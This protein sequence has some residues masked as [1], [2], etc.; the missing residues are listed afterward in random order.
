MTAL[1]IKFKN[2]LLAEATQSWHN[3]NN[4]EFELSESGN[5]TFYLFK[6]ITDPQGN[7][8]VAL[9]HTFT[10][11]KAFVKDFKVETMEEI[12]AMEEADLWQ[13]FNR[14]SADLQCHVEH[15]LHLFT[16]TNQIITLIAHN[17]EEKLSLPAF[18]F[19]RNE[20][21]I[22]YC[23]RQYHPRLSAVSTL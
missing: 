19:T 21:Y 10:S 23:I 22:N 4:I 18:Q 1:H 15:V 9:H 17:A 12:Q 16:K 2:L 3:K 6:T 7:L 14:G 5:I 13:A 20:D 8:C 11:C